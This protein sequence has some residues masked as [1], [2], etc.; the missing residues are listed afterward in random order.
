MGGRD[1]SPSIAIC[2]SF[3]C[4]AEQRTVA[5]KN[6][7]KDN[8]KLLQQAP[9]SNQ[10]G[11]V[12]VMDNKQL[13]VCIG[14]RYFS[15]KEC[16]RHHHIKSANLFGNIITYWSKVV[17]VCFSEGTLTVWLHIIAI[18]IIRRGNCTQNPKKEALWRVSSR[19]ES[20]HNRGPLAA[21]PAMWDRP[22]MKLG[23]EV[24]GGQPGNEEWT[25]TTKAAETEEDKGSECLPLCPADRGFQQHR[26]PCSSHCTEGSRTS[27]SCLP[28]KENPSQI[29]T[30]PILAAFCMIIGT[31]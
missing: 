19:W 23:R 30:T 15:R 18:I 22:W 1:T 7:C 26:C 2:C 11:S 10:W 12:T 27:W 16:L 13:F 17:V 20:A 9:T 3:T 28:H 24:S 25:G 5:Y 21:E 14:S 4:S 29:K 6:A 31:P 8:P